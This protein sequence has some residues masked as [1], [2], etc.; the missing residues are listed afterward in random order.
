MDSS[1]RTDLHFALNPTTG[2]FVF[3]NGER[4]GVPAEH[5]LIFAMY[6]ST[7]ADLGNLAA[8]AKIIPSDNLHNQPILAKLTQAQRSQLKHV[9]QETVEEGAAE[10]GLEHCTGRA[11]EKLH[12]HERLLHLD[13]ELT[14]HT[15]NQLGHRRD[16]AITTPHLACSQL[17]LESITLTRSGLCC[18]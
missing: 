1:Q 16:V 9:Q 4:G 3:G 7:Q 2:E 14:R 6:R 17:D 12:A 15:L 5:E 18:A 8:D 11:V 10:E 13:A